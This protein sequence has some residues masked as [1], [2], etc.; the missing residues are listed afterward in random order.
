MTDRRT[1]L[2]KC[3]AAVFASLDADEIPRATKVT[4]SGWD[5][6]ATITL[7]A[8]VEEEFGLRV[9]PEDI[10]RFVSFQ[11]ILNYLESRSA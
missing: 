3:F 7:L 9:S 4:V 6:V 5:S 8:V 2:E 1:R 11:A 10:T